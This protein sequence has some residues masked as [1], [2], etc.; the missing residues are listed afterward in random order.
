[1]SV[2]CLDT[3]VSG[4][5]QTDWEVILSAM[6]DER[7]YS[8][9][10]TGGGG[11]VFEHRYGSVMLCHLLS[12]SQVR[13]LGTDV[14]PDEVWFQ[15]LP[16]DSHVDDLVVIGHTEAKVRRTLSIAVRR[17]PELSKS[18]GKT[19]KLLRSFLRDVHERWPTMEAGE[20]TLSLAVAGFNNAARELR[21]IASFARGQNCETFWADYLFRLNTLEQKRLGHF[22]DLVRGAA[23]DVSITDLTAEELAWRV[24]H[25]LWVPMLRLEETDKADEAIAINLLRILEP[26]RVA[27]A[28]L[29][30]RVNELARDYAQRGAK[31]DRR[32]VLRHLAQDGYDLPELRPEPGPAIT[33]V[34]AAAPSE[35]VAG[36]GDFVAGST[37]RVGEREYLVHDHH[38]AVEVATDGAAVFRRARV[39][40]LA[41]KQF[42][43]FRQ[44]TDRHA[45]TAGAALARERDLAARL[46]FP[47]VMH[48]DRG[49]TTTLVT[50]WPKDRDNLPCRTVADVLGAPLTGA[51]VRWL[52]AG[53]VS[54]CAIVRRLHESGHTHRAWTPEGV[55]VRADGRW[56][57]RDLGLAAVPARIGEHVGDY[58]APEQRY[59]TGQ[60][61]GTWTDVYQ[62][63]AI[64]Y[65][66]LSGRVSTHTETQLPLTHG[67]PSIPDELADVIATALSRQA[68]KRQDIDAF[69]AGVSR[70]KN[71]IR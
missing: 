54:A 31:V 13:E 30:R 29:Y 5:R 16:K 59:R 63:A 47:W 9:Y 49:V 6:G 37:V 34:F 55:F 1:M 8:A 51:R 32:T 2:L 70:A 24:L 23:K 45:S 44:V 69:R 43:W 53:L 67:R 68:G 41:D 33:Y 10:S 62:L 19:R 50:G 46:A 3:R 35:A 4:P 71:H 28:N 22:L 18:D 58:Q 11:T 52:C 12:M 61:P 65:R 7:V 26:D 25:V 38:V 27:A 21:G 57:P 40:S 48:F 20:W 64:A 14:V 36:V 15:S 56:E 42:G 66:V 60:Q 17:A 39:T